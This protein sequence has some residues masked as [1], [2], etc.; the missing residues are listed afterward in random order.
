[1]VHLAP[2]I[3]CASGI[4]EYEGDENTKKGPGLVIIDFLEITSIVD[5][6]N[7]GFRLQ[8]INTLVNL[9]QILIC[10]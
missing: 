6:Y 1:M 5:T 3:V 8:K 2:G 4:I 7:G 10:I 9:S